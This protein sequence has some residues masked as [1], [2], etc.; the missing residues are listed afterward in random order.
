MEYSRI[1][2]LLHFCKRSDIVVNINTNGF[3]K[4]I[5]KNFGT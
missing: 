2:D 3:S 1:L 4:K 5:E